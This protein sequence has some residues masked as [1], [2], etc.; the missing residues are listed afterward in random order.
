MTKIRV[1]AV[2][3]TNSIPFIYGLQNDPLHNEISLSLDTPA[4]C[5]NNLLSGNAEVG[6]VPVIIK[7]HVS[8]LFQVSPFGI[9]AIGDVLSVILVSGCPL[10]K[11]KTVTLD[12]QSRTSVMLARLLCSDYWN[13][14]PVFLEAKPGFED[15]MFGEYEAKVIIGDRALHFHRQKDVYI[16]DLAGEWTKFTGLPFVFAIWASTTKL[17]IKFEQKFTD[18]LRYGLSC[19]EKLIIDLQTQPEYGSIDLSGYLNHNIIHEIN[20]PMLEG[21]NLFL[22]LIRDL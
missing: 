4:Q 16:T 19:K 9:G 18:A 8:Q 7:N 3:Y 11:V 1:S 21:M 17:P 10:N 15:A 13:I 12:Y 20:S 6:L 14:N 22:H 2:K 5:Y